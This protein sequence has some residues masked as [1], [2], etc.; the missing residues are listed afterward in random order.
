MARP[1]I[2]NPDA[3]LSA[4]MHCFRTKGYARVSIKD[5]EQATG[6]TSGSLYNSYES[7]EG[8]FR[9]ALDHYVEIVIKGRAK[10]FAGPEAG[11]DDLENLFMSIWEMPQADGFGCLVTNSAIEFGPN[12]PP[13]ASEKIA[14]GMS[15]TA[16]GIRTVLLRELGDEEGEREATH[17]TLVYHGMLVLSRSGVLAEEHRRSIRDLFARLNATRKTKQ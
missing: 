13:F 12:A 10:A 1:R 7:K 9:A 16:Q 8:L 17:L 11:L 6:A 15:I 14:D 2:F 4:A 5:L 3:V